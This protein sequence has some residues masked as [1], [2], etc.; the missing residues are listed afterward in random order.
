MKTYKQLPIPPDS[1][2]DRNKTTFNPY[3]LLD[4]FI[5]TKFKYSWL[6]AKWDKYIDDPINNIRHGVINLW[7]WFPTIW[8]S[9]RW[10][11]SFTLEILQK[12]LEL[13]RKELVEAN[14]H[15]GVSDVNR[16]ITLCLNLIERVN[17]DYYH[18]EYS[19]YHESK[20]EFIPCEDNPGYSTLNDDII[21]ENFDDYF[22]K[23][24]LSLRKVLE[25]DPELIEDRKWLAMNVGRYNQ[26]KCQTLL[27]K[28][29]DEKIKHFWD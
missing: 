10:D 6:H 22:K 13:Q 12:S 27:F 20:F 11:N 4:R 1:A 18:M 15:Q 21:S 17:D 29:L 26:T 23:Y 9:R 16:Y 24:P 2:W 19:D 3:K 28:I 8:R 14:R 7:A 25:K 5:Y